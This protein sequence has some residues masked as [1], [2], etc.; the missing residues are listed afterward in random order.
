MLS[1]DHEF[2]FELVCS[3]DAAYRYR[4]GGA[5]PPFDMFVRQFLQVDEPQFLV[6]GKTTL[7]KLGWVTSYR[8]DLESGTIYIGVIIMDPV[9]GSGIGVEAAVLFI[10]YLFTNWSFRKVYAEAPE[11]TMN[12]LGSGLHRYFEREG[13]LREHRYYAG[14]YWDEHILAVYRNGWEATA[15]RY[16]GQLSLGDSK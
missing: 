4:Y 13:T 8:R 14:K 15:R 9:V 12:A 11:F 1:G 10:N 7:E 2:L 16:F 3:Q 6:V 5:V